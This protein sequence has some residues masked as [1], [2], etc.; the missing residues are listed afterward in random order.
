[1]WAKHGNKIWIY[2]DQ[3]SLPLTY[4][5]WI[6]IPL[7]AGILV[8]KNFVHVECLFTLAGGAGYSYVAADTGPIH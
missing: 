1:M 5:R 8:F 2:S 7:Y 6:H 4:L 3:D